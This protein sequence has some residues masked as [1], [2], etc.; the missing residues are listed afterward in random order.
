[1]LD[2]NDVYQVEGHEEMMREKI[3]GGKKKNKGD[4]DKKL[5]PN[6]QKKLSRPN[7]QPKNRMSRRA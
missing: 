7:R 2:T 4:N 5:R 6:R 3:K 1:M